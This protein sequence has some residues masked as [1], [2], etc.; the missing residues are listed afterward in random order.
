MDFLPSPRKKRRVRGIPGA[1]LPISIDSSKLRPNDKLPNQIYRGI[2]DDGC[3]AV[4]DPESADALWHNGY[5]G[6]KR[7]HTDTLD[8][9][10]GS[11]N[12]L[13]QNRKKQ[14]KLMCIDDLI[15]GQVIE[16]EME[17]Q[18][19]EINEQME[20]YMKKFMLGGKEELKIE[21]KEMNCQQSYQEI[22]EEGKRE[23]SSEERDEAPMMEK[24]VKEWRTVLRF[25]DRH[26][27][28]VTNARHSEPCLVLLP[29]EAFFLCYA[30]GCLI[31]SQ[32]MGSKSGDDKRKKVDGS[33]VCELSLDELWTVFMEDDPDFATKYVV[34]HHYRTKGWVVKC[35]LKYGADWVLYPVGPPFYH[36]QYTVTMHCLWDDTLTL[37]DNCP[38]RQLS[39]TLLATTERVTTHVNKTPVLCFVL[40]PRTLTAVDLRHI[41]CLQ[42]LRI[43]EMV[44]ARWSPKS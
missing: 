13:H 12:H 2:Y 30:L 28:T 22:M 14:R 27:R 25:E 10:M 44:V 5:F 21:D 24:E 33:R 32:K 42:Q 16:D 41:K 43:Q 7:Q 17:E 1:P 34:Y 38:E 18:D 6:E 26:T 39:W 36:A 11:R 4:W 15:Q 19:E 29:V 40:W 37:I 8:L 9:D 23:I 35:G 3:V 31:V 20:N